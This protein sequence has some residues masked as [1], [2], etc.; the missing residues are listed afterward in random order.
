MPIPRSAVQV[1]GG[2]FTPHLEILIAGDVI[3]ALVGAAS[4]T[5]SSLST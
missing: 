5:A 1:P 4:L 2:S 3:R